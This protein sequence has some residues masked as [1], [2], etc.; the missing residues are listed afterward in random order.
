[1]E[2]F[3]SSDIYV[4][5]TN[6]QRIRSFTDDV[7]HV[8]ALQKKREKVRTIFKNQKISIIKQREDKTILTK[9]GFSVN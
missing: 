2:A 7:E 4:M 3:H 1:M 8:K 9:I 5:E 6:D